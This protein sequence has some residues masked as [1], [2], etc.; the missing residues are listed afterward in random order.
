MEQGA[1]TRLTQRAMMAWCVPVVQHRVLDAMASDAIT[2]PMRRVMTAWCAAA[3]CSRVLGHMAHSATTLVQARV[4]QGS[5]NRGLD[6]D[7]TERRPAHGV[8]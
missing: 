4:R 5:D 6:T 2:R 7:D 1:I 3:L 8:G